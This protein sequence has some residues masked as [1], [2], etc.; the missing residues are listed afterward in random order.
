MPSRGIDS[1]ST[2]EFDLDKNYK[3]SSEIQQDPQKSSLSKATI[4][5]DSSF[6]DNVEDYNQKT[7]IYR[8]S[9]YWKEIKGETIYLILG[10]ASAAISCAT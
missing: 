5:L 3:G 9:Y 10:D 6:M 8:E 4:S 7:T 1:H 2:L